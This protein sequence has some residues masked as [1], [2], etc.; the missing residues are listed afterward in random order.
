MAR[1][2][3]YGAAARIG[4]DAFPWGTLFVNVAGSLG[5]GFFAAWTGPEGRLLV[6]P[7]TRI[8]VMTG[9]FGGFTTFSTFSFETLR[10]LQDRQWLF[11]GLNVSFSVLLCLTGVWAG[12]ELATALIRK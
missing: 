8:F 7:E 1:Y 6:R 12:H 9:F 3:C 11:A 4:A 5:I 2:W 10:L